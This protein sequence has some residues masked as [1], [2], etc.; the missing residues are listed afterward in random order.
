MNTLNAIEARISANYFD[1]SRKLSES[2]IYD[3]IRYAQEAPSAFNIQHT[4]YLVVTD[5]GAKDALKD[6]AFGQQKVSDAAA[7]F[8]LFGDLRGHERMAEIGQRAVDAGV[9]NAGVRD[10]LVHAVDG[11][12]GTNP[13]MVRDEA[14][15]SASLAGMSLM[16]AATAKG[17]ASGP[18]IGF[19]GDKLR[20]VFRVSDRY[21]PVMMITAGYARAGNWTRKPRFTAQEVAVMD[22][23]PNA[24][25][26]LSE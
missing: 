25:H 2:E 7:V 12:Y 20:E 9:F 8:V 19:D 1:T 22:A 15:R 11:T 17:L 5:Q 24:E 10:Y 14:I 13:A 3:L 16:L 23:R 26:T 4:R 6:I 21:L 18:M